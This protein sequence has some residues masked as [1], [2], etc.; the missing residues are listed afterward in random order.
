MPLLAVAGTDRVG[1]CRLKFA[2][3]NGGQKTRFL[4]FIDICVIS[5]FLPQSTGLARC[6][7]FF[8]QTE[9]NVFTLSGLFVVQAVT[10]TFHVVSGRPRWCH[11]GMNLNSTLLTRRY[12]AQSPLLPT[13]P[14]SRRFL[15]RGT[16]LSRT[17]T[18]LACRRREQVSESVGC[19]SA[20]AKPAV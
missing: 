15:F 5:F 4:L 6:L 16:F 9:L 14:L 18:R 13:Q 8:L 10:C 11:V 19:A 20:S 12:R 2:C 3:P 7:D 17:I 1:F